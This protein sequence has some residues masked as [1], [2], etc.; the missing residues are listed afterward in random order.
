MLYLRAAFWLITYVSSFQS[1]RK[2]QSLTSTS[3]FQLFDRFVKRRHEKLRLDGY[4]DFHRATAQHRSVPLQIVSLWNTFLL[5]IQTLIQHYYGD[6]FA[7][8]CAMVGLL[9]PIVYITLFSSLETMVFGIVHGLYIGKL[10]GVVGLYTF[11]EANYEFV[12]FRFF[13]S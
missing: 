4:H 9:S 13:H 10:G 8:K 2:D 1:F 12:G 7:E 3:I 5:A 11:L 6:S